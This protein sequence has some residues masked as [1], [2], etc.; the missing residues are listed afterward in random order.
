MDDSTKRLLQ[1][2]VRRIPAQMLRTTL[3]KWGRLTAAQQKS[4]DFTQPKWLLAERLL[5]I[6]EVCS[7]F[8]ERYDVVLNTCIQCKMVVH[9][10]HGPYQNSWRSGP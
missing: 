6:C 2:L 9:Q 3:D 4:M 1:R 8:A 10:R 5:D 7:A